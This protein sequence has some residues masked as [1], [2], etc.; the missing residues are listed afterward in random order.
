MITVISST[1]RRNSRTLQFAKHYLKTF[2]AH[3]SEAQLLALETLPPALFNPEMYTQEGQ[4]EAFRTLQEKYIINADKF[5]FVVPEYNG[6]MPGA[7]KLFIDACSVYNIKGSFSGKKAGIAGIAVGRAGNLRGMEHLTAILN[8][9]EIIVMP[10]RQPVSAIKNLVDTEGNIIDQ[11]TITV[12][13]R[14]V[15]QFINF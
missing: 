8:F 6:G 1:N 9:L 15:D 13:E 7:L 11:A 10:Q 5:F 3:H 12:I 4:P 14:Q 2:Q